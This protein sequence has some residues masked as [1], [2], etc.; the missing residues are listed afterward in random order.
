MDEKT[1]K[2]PEELLQFKLPENNQFPVVL[3]VGLTPLQVKDK[4]SEMFVAMQERGVK[5]ERYMTDEEVSEVRAEYGDLAE[6]QMPELKA[7]LEQLTAVYKREKENLVDRITSLDVQ[8]KDLVY[9]AK[10]GVTVFEPEPENTFKIPVAG[11]YLYYTLTGSKF[12]LID[13]KLIPDHQRYDL[14][15]TGDKNKQSFEAAG[16]E[17]P[18]YPIENRQNYRVIELGVDDYVEIW[19]ENGKE[20]TKHHWV[21]DFQDEDT[22]EVAS[23]DRNE[24]EEFEIGEN[25]Y[26]NGKTEAQEGETDEISGEPEG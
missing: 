9:L 20:R 13:V 23:L 15:N 19:E 12:Q 21:E 24:T 8:F 2:I 7:Q 17:I 25:P 16:F 14:F 4:I 6:S 1:K 5:A 3:F 11:H 26:E 10:Q 18:D 22:G